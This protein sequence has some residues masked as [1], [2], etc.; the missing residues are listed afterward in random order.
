MGTTIPTPLYELY[1]Q[2]FGFSEFMITVIFATYAVGVITS[3]VLFGH[4]SDHIGRRP[5]LLTALAASALSAVCFLTSAG[6]PLLLIGRLVSGLAAGVFTGTATATLID[7]AA[8]GE[9]T[10]AT[11]TATLANMSGLGFGP[12]L[13][14]ALAAWA[15]SPLRLVFWVY[16]VFLVPAAIGIWAAPE[17]VKARTRAE[18]RLQLLRVP[19]DMRIFFTDAAVAAFAGYAVLGLF[20]AVAPAFLG[21]DLGVTSPAAV[22]LAVFSVFAASAVGQRLMSVTGQKVALPAGCGVLV[23]GMGLLVLSLSLSSLTLLILAGLVSGLGQGM[24]FRAGLAGLNERAP[25]AQ[26]AR[27][28]SSFFV[29]CYLAISVPVIGEG[30]LTQLTGLRP[31]GF[32]FAAVVAALALAALALLARTNPTAGRISRPVIR[33]TLVPKENPQ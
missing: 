32:V 13:A 19:A 1:R 11:L 24:S 28:A 26:R 6:L 16:L 33:P 18:F 5:M 17:P 31:A 9:R 7:L 25:A 22:G 20:S 4:L 10:R 21:Q 14:G 2:Q 27:V 12:L 29:V 8:P 3:L 23:L 15:G 30:V